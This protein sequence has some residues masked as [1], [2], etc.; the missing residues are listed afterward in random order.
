MDGFSALGLAANLVAF[1]E[2]AWTLLTESVQVYRSAEG[3]ILALQRIA[4]EIRDFN[5]SLAP[6]HGL[7]P[8]TEA[9]AKAASNLCDELLDPVEK[10]LAGERKPWRSFVVALRTIWSRDKLN[11]MLTRIE[12]YQRVLADHIQA[13]TL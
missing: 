9:I 13:M 2:F 8:K 10:L 3:D 6:A 11:N 12:R 5:N 4:Q 7:T 1:V